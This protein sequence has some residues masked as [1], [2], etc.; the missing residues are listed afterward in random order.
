MD[1]RADSGGA[2]VAS[3]IVKAQNLKLHR[4]TQSPPSLLLIACAVGAGRGRCWRATIRQKNLRG[5]W[6]LTKLLSSFLS[7]FRDNQNPPLSFA[8]SASEGLRQSYFVLRETQHV[9]LATLYQGKGWQ[10]PLFYRMQ[11]ASCCSRLFA[12]VCSL[13]SFCFAKVCVCVCVALDTY[14][15]LM[16]TCELPN[17]ISRYYS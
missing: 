2:A 12:D 3:C 6:K 17:L 13:P 11:L 10:S 4:N 8:G 14:S 15:M 9:L 1:L 5:K 16:C 7:P